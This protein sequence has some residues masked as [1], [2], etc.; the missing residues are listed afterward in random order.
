MGASGLRMDLLHQHYGWHVFLTLDCPCLPTTSVVPKLLPRLALPQVSA[1]AAPQERG[2]PVP[3]RSGEDQFPASTTLQVLGPGSKLTVVVPV[4][5]HMCFACP[6]VM[7][8]GSGG[9]QEQTHR[10]QPTTTHRWVWGPDSRP[11]T[12]LFHAG[13]STDCCQPPSES[14]ALGIQ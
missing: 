5:I 1:A 12:W 9:N 2:K 10:A 6:V 4:P 7:L 3:V 14:S 11:P 8:A 13:I